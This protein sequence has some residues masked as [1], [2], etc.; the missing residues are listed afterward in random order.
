M[1]NSNTKPLKYIFDIDG[2]ICSQEKD[3]FDAKPYKDM[4]AKI[5]QLYDAGHEIIFYTARGTETGIDWSDITCDQLHR[6]G[7]K[8]H[9]MQTGKMAADIYVDDRGCNAN[10]FISSG[11]TDSL[12]VVDKH[13]GKEYLIDITKQYAMKKLHIDAG[14]NISLQYHVKKNETWHIVNGSGVARIDGKEF[15][16]HTGDTVRIPA[17]TI[18]QVRAITDLVII[19]SSTTE[20]DDIV[21]IKEDF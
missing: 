16:V 5:N 17:G 3:Y 21:R 18:H 1:Q 8:Y 7:V 11:H 12:T 20:L 13:W 10:D 9:K 6:W 14:K 2:T 4:I 15:N 19:E